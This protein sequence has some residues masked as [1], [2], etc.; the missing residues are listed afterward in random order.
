[1][2]MSHNS[3]TKEPP[4][5]K[6]IYGEEFIFGVSLLENILTPVNRTSD[7]LQG[8][9]VDM[10]KARENVKL[11]ID[12]L[13]GLKNE[14][15][16]NELWELA[17]KKSTNLK[18][19]VEKDESLDIYFDF[20][21]AKIPRRLQWT[22]SPIEYYRV[23]HYEA[24]LDKIIGNLNVRFMDKDKN[25]VLDLVTI[26]NDDKVA[27]EVFENVRKVYGIDAEELNSEHRMFQHFKVIEQF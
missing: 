25:I 18:S 13:E 3:K 2:M 17:Q 6:N 12:T 21:E 23:T 24:A 27:A 1:M 10:R 11:L 7:Y 14:E 16:F 26:V 9:N 20:E 15:K 4:V 8:R 5:Y 22:R 19:F